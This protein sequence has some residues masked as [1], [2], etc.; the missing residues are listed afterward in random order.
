MIIRIS[1][2]QAI[3]LDTLGNIQMALCELLSKE[4]LE[5]TDYSSDPD[6]VYRMF[7]YPDEDDV[8]L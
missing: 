1:G 7:F 6:G 4:G 5:L 2:H 8:E 3:S